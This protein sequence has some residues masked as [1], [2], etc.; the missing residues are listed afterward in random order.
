MAD[1]V[2]IV[3]EVSGKLVVDV[4]DSAA[5]I[6]DEF[7]LRHFVFDVR[8]CEVDRQHYQRET[9][10]VDGVYTR[11]PASSQSICWVRSIILLGQV[12]QCNSLYCCTELNVSMVTAPCQHVFGISS[13]M[14]L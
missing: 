1:Q 6:P 11:Q 10:D 13:Q 2:D 14:H 3:I 9:D 5:R 7:S 12:N 8:T 4:S